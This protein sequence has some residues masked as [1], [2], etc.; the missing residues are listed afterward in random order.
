[1]GASPGIVP[2]TLSIS[3][4]D[5]TLIVSATSASADVELRVVVATKRDGG[6]GMILLGSWISKPTVLVLP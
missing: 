1:M 6:E 5:S 4:S 3:F 2:A